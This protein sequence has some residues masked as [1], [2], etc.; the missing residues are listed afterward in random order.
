MS[1]A[2]GPLQC[3]IVAVLSP[4]QRR[5]ALSRFGRAPRAEMGRR[6]RNG[7][8]EQKRGDGAESARLG[9]AATWGQ[10]PESRTAS[11]AKW[12]RP[13]RARLSLEAPSASSSQCPEPRSRYPRGRLVTCMQVELGG[14]RLSGSHT[15]APLGVITPRGRG[16]QFSPPEYQKHAPHVVGPHYVNVC[17]L[18][19]D[20]RV[21]P[22]WLEGAETLRKRS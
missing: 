20:S 11:S 19:N 16:A 22:P 14:T 5:Q 7:E 6:S 3:H 4:W 17:F 12:Q 18:G 15:P 21:F 1:Q 8:T 2:T 9:P 10:K 13:R